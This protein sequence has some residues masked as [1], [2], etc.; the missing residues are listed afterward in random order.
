MTGPK[1]TQSQ[2]CLGNTDLF[3]ESSV[4]LRKKTLAVLR[5]K[6]TSFCSVILG[7]HLAASVLFRS[8]VIY[9][10]ENNSYVLQIAKLRQI[11]REELDQYRSKHQQRK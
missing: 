1:A 7:A 5:L 9:G 2:A 8:V 3:R 4:L 11:L 6:T 10:E